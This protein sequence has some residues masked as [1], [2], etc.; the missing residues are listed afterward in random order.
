M[1]FRVMAG[2][3]AWASLASYRAPSGGVQ[4]FFDGNESLFTSGRHTLTLV[5]LKPALQI[6]SAGGQMI[7]SLQSS[8]KIDYAAQNRLFSVTQIA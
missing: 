1:R 2:H 4:T 3:R 8:G 5:A 6:Y 7:P